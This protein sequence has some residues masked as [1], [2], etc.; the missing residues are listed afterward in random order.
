MVCPVK[1]LR[2]ISATVDN[3]YRNLVISRILLSLLHFK[4]DLEKCLQFSKLKLLTATAT[5][6]LTFLPRLM[7]TKMFQYLGSKSR[8]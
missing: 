5:F 6:S 3:L 8:L 2:R 4:E 7:L 1:G